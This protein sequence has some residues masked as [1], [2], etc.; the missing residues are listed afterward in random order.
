MTKYKYFKI[1][2]KKG[3]KKAYAVVRS[4]AKSPKVSVSKVLKK[5]KAKIDIWKKVSKKEA[6]EF[7]KRGKGYTGTKKTRVIIYRRK[8]RK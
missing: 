5:H 8:R 2:A 1:T 6:T 7:A 3:K 4:S